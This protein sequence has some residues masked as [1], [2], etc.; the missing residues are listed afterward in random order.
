M[1]LAEGLA[2]PIIAVCSR[3]PSLLGHASEHRD[4]G[5]NLESSGSDPD[6]LPIPLSLCSQLSQRSGDPTP[7]L[8]SK[9]C[10]RATHTITARTTNTHACARDSARSTAALFPS[11]VFSC[12]RAWAIAT[13]Q[14]IGGKS[15][16]G[17]KR[18][19]WRAARPLQKL[20]M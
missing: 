20:L 3:A 18:K 13:D 12:Q 17:Q 10:A 8:L 11:W 2:P 15:Q 16:S 6:A 7:P 5:S 19:A 1:E 14:L 4:Q 9:V